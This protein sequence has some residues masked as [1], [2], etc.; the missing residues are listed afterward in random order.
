M[1]GLVHRRIAAAGIG[2]QAVLLE[3]GGGIIVAGF[4]HHVDAPAQ[5]ARHRRAVALQ[6]RHHLDHAVAFQDAAQRLRP[7]YIGQRVGAARRE[8]QAV[9]RHIEPA[10]IGDR[11]HLDRRLGAVE[12]RVEHLRVHAGAPGLVGGEAVMLPHAVRRD[13]VIGRQIF[14]AFAGRRDGEARGARPVDH[15]GNQ[16]RLVAVSERIDDA[17]GARLAREPGAG[18]R[19]GLDIDHDDML[20]G[21]DR[22]DRM[23]NA[24]RRI[25][26]RLDHDLDALGRDRRR[27]HPRQNASARSATHPSRRC[28]TPPW[29]APGR[30]RRSPRPPGP[31]ID[32][33]WARNIEPNFPAPISPTRTGLLGIYARREEGLQVQVFTPPPPC[34]PARKPA[35]H[36]RRPERAEQNRGARSSPAG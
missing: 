19:V 18:Q 6:R 15:L 27:G 10:G 9:V 11:R 14:G 23:P 20:A 16:R 24:G 26:G 36:R 1:I 5:I 29:R 31:A 32:G 8:A 13:R 30:D 34:G 28:G 12:K 17:S 33:T 35:A 3:A 22:R 7:Q 21:V 4:E 2:R 25:A